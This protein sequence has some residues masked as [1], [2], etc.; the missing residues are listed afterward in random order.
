MP[1]LYKGDLFQAY[2]LLK[3]LRDN[4][5][6]T[7]RYNVYLPGFGVTDPQKMHDILVNSGIQPNEGDEWVRVAGVKLAVDGGFEGGHMTRP[8]VGSYGQGVRSTG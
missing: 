4:G 8:Y 6:L 3:Q 1:G 7:L 5:Q 2:K